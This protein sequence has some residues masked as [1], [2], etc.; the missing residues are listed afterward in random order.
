MSK[1]HQYYKILRADM[2]HQG[3][4]YEYDISMCVPT[5]MYFCRLNSIP[6]W[7]DLYED[8]EVIAE[9]HFLPQ[10]HVEHLSA[11]KSRVDWFELRNPVPIWKFVRRYFEP[12]DLLVRSPFSIRYIKSPSVTLQFFAIEE[13][14]HSLACIEAPNPDVCELA[15]AK[16][17]LCIQYV[18]YHTI[19]LYRIAVEQN[20]LALSLVKEEFWKNE[21]YQKKMEGLCL[22]AVKQNGFA[23]QFVRRQTQ[24]IC[25]AAVAQNGYAIAFVLPQFKTPEVCRLAWK[26]NSQT[27]GLTRPDFQRAVMKRREILLH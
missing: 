19:D 6:R 22:L 23:L 7:I 17:G 25:E 2:N 24:E 1:H 13:D 14:P 15:V 8:N 5:G 27:L 4:Q 18:P 9:V 26:Q 11:H 3:I 16:N 21:I 10:S 20:G 12:I